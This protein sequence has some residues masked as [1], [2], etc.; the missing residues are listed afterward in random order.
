MDI[1]IYYDPMISKLIA[2]GKNREAA[3]QRILEAINM[4][5]VE[6]VATTLPFGRFVFQHEAFISGKFDTHFV[7]KYFTAEALAEEEEKVAAI[8]AELAARR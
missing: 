1:P 8:A 5:E 2:Y 7:Q 4:Y 3:I 6:G